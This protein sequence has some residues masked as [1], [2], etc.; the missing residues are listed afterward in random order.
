MGFDA[1]QYLAEKTAPQGNSAPFDPKRYLSEKVSKSTYTGIND[2]DLNPLQKFEKNSQGKWYGIS[3][4][5]DEIFSPKKVE[6]ME[7]A[8]LPI[9]AGLLAGTAAV[10]APVVGAA[11]ATPLGKE[12]IKEA[13]KYGSGA[14]GAGTAVGILKRSGYLP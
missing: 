14:L 2:E 12:L 7:D 6:A 8:A 11:A 3:K 10:G 1:K 13:L 5:G 4:P 9:G